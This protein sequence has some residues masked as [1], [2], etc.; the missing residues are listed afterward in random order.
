MAAKIM[1]RD[2]ML[3]WMEKHHP[4]G[5]PVDLYDIASHFPRTNFGTM[6][7]AARTLDK[8]EKANFDGVSLRT[9]AK[10]DK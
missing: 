10:E 3:K 6:M 2:R 7:K 8:L 4:G 5:D 9:L 1:L